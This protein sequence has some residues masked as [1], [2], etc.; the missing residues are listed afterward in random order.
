MFSETFMSVG[1]LMGWLII[2][3]QYFIGV[4]RRRNGLY[5]VKNRCVFLLNFRSHL[6]YWK[7]PFSLKTAEVDLWGEKCSLRDLLVIFRDLDRGCHPDRLQ[8]MGSNGARV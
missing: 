6:V 8:P 5:L 2:D 4:M 7:C 3:V 1:V